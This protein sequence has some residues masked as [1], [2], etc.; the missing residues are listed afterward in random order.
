MSDLK[1]VDISEPKPREQSLNIRIDA[2][3]IWIE[4]RKPLPDGF[5][6]PLPV[7][8]IA[9]AALVGIARELTGD[10]GVERKTR[11]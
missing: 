6:E 11:T 8:R 4:W 9:A 10:G 2:Q 7:E 3:R 5:E 1:T